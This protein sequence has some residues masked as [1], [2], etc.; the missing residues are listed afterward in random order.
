MSSK[1]RL[2]PAYCRVDRCLLV[3]FEKSLEIMLESLVRMKERGG[4]IL[5]V[6]GIHR[7]ARTSIYTPKGT[8]KFTHPLPPVYY[9]LVPRLNIGLGEGLEEGELF[10]DVI[11][12]RVCVC[13]Y[14][15][16]VS[17]CVGRRGRRRF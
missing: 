13:F 17:Y 2:A 3:R 12:V 15:S 10:F 5:Q 9:E 4:R 8:Y 6:S 1:E 16:H 7:S 14:L 11:R